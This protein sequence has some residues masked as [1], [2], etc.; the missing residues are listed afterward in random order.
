MQTKKRK[1]I[2]RGGKNH[3]PG[4]GSQC[5]RGGR[6]ASLV[7]VIARPITGWKASSVYRLTGAPL[8]DPS[9]R[10][11]GRQVGTEGERDGGRRFVNMKGG[12]DG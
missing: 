4:R 9:L 8:Q 6:E 10:Q 12:R 2:K 1:K 5:R 11:A 3:T 7:V